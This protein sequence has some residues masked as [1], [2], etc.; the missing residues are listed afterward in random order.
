MDRAGGATGPRA[1]HC[2]DRRFDGQ[3]WWAF[4]PLTRP[5]LPAV[6]SRA[7]VRTPIDAFILGRLEAERLHPGPEADR[8]T[9]IRRLTFDLHGLPPT[10]EEIDAFLA[11]DA[12]DAYE[13]LV[14]RLLASPRYGERW[15]RHWLDVV[16]YGDT[17]GYD[18]DKR[19]DHAWP[20]RDY[21]IRS[22]NEDVPYARFVR[23][24]IAGDV[25]EPGDPP[26]V[27]RH[28]VHRG[29]PVGLRR[30]RRAARGDRREAQDPPASTA[31]TWW[32]TPCPPSRA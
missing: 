18:K 25:L 6:A 2:E 30:P 5:P 10:P 14:D 3:A 22:F 28:R 32:P 19:R 11:D 4:R 1:W 13:K 23:E 31:T 27:D 17:H 16:H 15:G 12:P 7:W 24:Q 21:V 29:R 20:Y 8:R 26:G 9:L